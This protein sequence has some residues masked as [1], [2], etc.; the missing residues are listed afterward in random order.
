MA[1]VNHIQLNRI[2]GK[3]GELGPQYVTRAMPH[4]QSE[5]RRLLQQQITAGTTPDGTPWPL[6]K[7]DG[8]K[9]LQDA[10]K[11][12]T[13]EIVGHTLIVRVGGVEG[14]HHHGQIKGKV[15]RQI[16]P[17]RRDVPATW[18]RALRGVLDSLWREWVRHG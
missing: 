12:V 13:T 1:T 15:K 14:R 2:I 10:Y 5:V 3:L 18:A 17:W 6:R 9:A 4:V 16:L 7:A 11:A 8:G